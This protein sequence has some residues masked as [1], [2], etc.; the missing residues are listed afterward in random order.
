MHLMSKNIKAETLADES[1]KPGEA[2]WVWFVPDLKR[3]AG[4][5]R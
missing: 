3:T 1:G 4:I 5:K 2:K